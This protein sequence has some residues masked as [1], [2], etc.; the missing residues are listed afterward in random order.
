[1]KKSSTVT[2]GL[3]ASM[4]FSACQSHPTRRCVDRN[5]AVVDDTLCLNEE[6]TIHPPGYIPYY[7]W[8]FPSSTGRL[9]RSVGP[10]IAPSSS[11]PSSPTSS[12][13]VTR[14]GFGSTGRGSAGS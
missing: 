6:K 7:H 2:L 4:A 10:I 11:R 13:G 3:L 12:H 14:G 9:G 8:Y 1:M 5:N